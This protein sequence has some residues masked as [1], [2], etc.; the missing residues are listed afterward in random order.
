MEMAVAGNFV[1]VF[2]A[3]EGHSNPIGINYLEKIQ[4]SHLPS[5]YGALLA[6][7][8]VVIVGAGIPLAFPETMRRLAR[9]ERAIYP[10]NVIG[11]DGRNEVLEMAFD[12]SELFDVSALSELSLPDFLPI[13][14]S[15]ALASIL[16]RRAGEGIDGF[17]IESNLAG[18]HNA[19]PRG[20]VS[21]SAE[22]EPIYGERDDAKLSAFRKMGL[23]FWLA[24]SVGSPEGL[25]TAL[26]EG[27]AGVQ[28]GTAFALCEESGLLPH[29]RHELIRL[30]LAG[31]A[32]IFTDPLASPTGFPFKVADLPGTLTDAAVYAARRRRCD[33][34]FLRQPY[35][36]PDGAI[37]Y[38]CPAEPVPAYLAKGGAEEDTLGRKCLCNALVANI[39]MPQIRP[40]G[41]EEPCLVTLGDDLLGV[42]RFCRGESPEFSADDVV[43]V[44]LGDLPEKAG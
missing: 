36:Q 24:G 29:L 37:G 22:G 6:G 43:A 41:R 31:K 26:E 11:A 4:I 25:R 3:K 19:P 18:G 21:Y 9:H 8:D 13:V 10:V 17:V 1:E 30:A 20:K 35:R 15:D 39:G 7:V 5:L 33:L 32:R 27:A 12:P 16:L 38:R 23:P 28:V 42:R 40:D 44:L 2:L 34:G 14:S